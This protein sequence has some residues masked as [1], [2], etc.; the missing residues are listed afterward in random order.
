[1]CFVI[2]FGFK[3]EE[4]EKMLWDRQLDGCLPNW[5]CLPTSTYRAIDGGCNH[6]DNLQNLGRGASGYR[7]FLLPAY[8]DGNILI[9]WY[10]YTYSFKWQV[11]NFFNIQ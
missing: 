1:V 7:R 9:F 5:Y 4:V 11:G 10:P 2:R 8:D 6:R 3:D